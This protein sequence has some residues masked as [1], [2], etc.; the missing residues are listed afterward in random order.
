[1][2]DIT[3]RMSAQ[4]WRESWGL[5]ADASPSPA[6]CQ[7]ERWLKGGRVG[8]RKYRNLPVVLDG[9]SYDSK[10]ELRHHQALLLARNAIDPEQRV[11]DVRRQQGYVLVE[12][13]GAERAV[14]YFADFVVTFADGNVEVHD[15]KS[16]P[17]RANSTYVIKRKLML[18]V[19][20]ICI[21]E[22]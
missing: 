6:S 10:K 17:T 12:A 21:R 4:A 22:V 2:A 9:Q 15:T 11:V 13:H 20:G 19:H 18:A 3:P 8:G 5:G 7:S 14:R 16:P 1:M